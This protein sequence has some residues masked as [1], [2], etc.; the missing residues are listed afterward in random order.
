MQRTTQ[1]RLALLASAATLALL[2]ACS[3]PVD[4]PEPPRTGQAQVEPSGPTAADK[5]A[6]STEQ[7]GRATADGADKAGT[8]VADGAD[9]AGNAV[10]RGAQR[11]AK[12][13]GDAGVT[14]AAKAALLAAPDLSALRIDVDTKG[15]VVTLKGNV[16]SLNEKSK[17]EQVVASVS[18]VQSVVND[19]RVTG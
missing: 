16:K 14:A 18:G 13:T 2:A 15:G 11:A 8:V 4:T 9:K 1:P 3:R 12:A 19:L 17:A 7:A 10:E 6:R 5:A